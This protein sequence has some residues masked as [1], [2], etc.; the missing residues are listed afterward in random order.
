MLNRHNFY[1]SLVWYRANIFKLKL[2][3]Q[4]RLINLISSADILSKIRILD[5]LKIGP[6][7]G[8][9]KEQSVGFS[10]WSQLSVQN[11]MEMYPAV[12]E[13]F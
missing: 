4:L 10:L 1:H 9:G 13:I 3:V 6:D 5:N 11:F 8:A 12:V 7:G 2:T